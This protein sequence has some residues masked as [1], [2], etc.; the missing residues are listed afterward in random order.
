MVVQDSDRFL[1][2]RIP[3]ADNRAAFTRRMHRPTA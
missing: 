3:A 2:P 1:L